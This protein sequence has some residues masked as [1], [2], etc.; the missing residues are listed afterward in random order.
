MIKNKYQNG[1][2]Y[3]IVND[4][5]NLTYYGS[6]IEKLCRRMSKHRADSKRFSKRYEKFGNLYDC[7][8]IL[9][10]N[11]PCNNKEELI[12]RERFYIENNKCINFEIPG[13]TKKEYYHD[14]KEQIKLKNQEYKL[15]NK[16]KIKLLNKEYYQKNKEK[17]L[18]RQKKYDEKN[19]EYKKQYYQKKKW[20]N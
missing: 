17:I 18:L 15:L 12:K 16:E 1:K 8:I 7:K 19:K 9:I 20:K 13:R 6:T 5:E 3:K 11:Y 14:N 4:V 2:I 10:E